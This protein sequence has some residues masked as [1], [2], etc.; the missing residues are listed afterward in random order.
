MLFDARAGSE[1]WESSMSSVAGAGRGWH[2]VG[3]GSR[4]RVRRCLCEGISSCCWIR[5]VG[6]EGLVLVIIGS[7]QAGQVAAWAEGLRLK[8]L[9][10]LGGAQCI[11]GAAPGTNSSPHVP[12]S[13][14]SRRCESPRFHLSHTTPIGNSTSDQK[15][16]DR[17]RCSMR[18]A[19]CLERGCFA[20]LADGPGR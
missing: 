4:L 17:D 8:K 1:R 20:F 3:V 9:P 6:G 16:K 2:R 12:L 19:F 13:S 14:I 5:L 10:L 7:G 15:T 11:H 18:I